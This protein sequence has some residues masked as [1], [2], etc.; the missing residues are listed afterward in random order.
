[1]PPIRTF[2]HALKHW[3]HEY[4]HELTRLTDPDGFRNKVRFVA[5]GTTRAA[6][7]A[8]RI[9]V[10][11]PGPYSANVTAPGAPKTLRQTTPAQTPISSPKIWLISAAVMKSP[12]APKTRCRR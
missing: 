3:R 6:R 2:Q 1:M 8:S 4:R 5:T 10:P 11:L 9:I 7:S 12:V